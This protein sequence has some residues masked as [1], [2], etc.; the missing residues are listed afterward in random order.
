LTV[1]PSYLPTLEPA[2]QR[3]E[4]IRRTTRQSSI[5]QYAVARETLATKREA[6]A[7]RLIA[8]YWNRWQQSPTIGMIAA[9]MMFQHGV[10]KA[11]PDSWQ[12]MGAR[13]WL[14]RGVSGLVKRGLV[15]PVPQGMRECPL[16]GVVV[17]TWRIT[18]L[19]RNKLT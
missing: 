8:A 5:Q 14:A 16:T 10:D 19:G 6:E 15:E 13:L 1:T 11:D 9:Q 18:L 2:V 7:L 4:K 3:K 17:H 12:F